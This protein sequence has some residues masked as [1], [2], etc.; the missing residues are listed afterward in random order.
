M[1]HR[2]PEKI[3]LPLRDLQELFT[4]P[5]FH[6]AE[7][8][9]GADSAAEA[10]QD[11]DELYEPGMDYLVS[12]LRGSRLRRRG[13]LV[14]ALPPG[15]VR[16]E[17]MAAAHRAIDRYCRHKILESKRALNEVLWTGLK[18]LQV[19]VLFLAG[20]LV[21]AAAIAQSNVAPGSFDDV[22]TQGLTIIGWVSL[23][24]PVETFLYDWW[25]LWRDVRVYDYIQRMEITLQPRR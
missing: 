14:L 20:C 17:I 5:E 4:A 1:R 11:E 22:A 19:G 10:C 15:A 24:R 8:Q 13:Q 12:R 18:S 9:A 25:P 7:I 21:L 6:P 3:A 2:Q 23:W 16:P